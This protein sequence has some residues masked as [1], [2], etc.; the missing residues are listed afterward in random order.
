MKNINL[1]DTRKSENE[2]FINFLNS[3]PLSPPRKLEEQLMKEIRLTWYPQKRT[4]FSKLL[5]IQ[6]TIGTLTMLACPQFQMSLTNNHEVFHYF[7]YHF[8]ET[9]CM[10]ICGSILLG[11]GAVVASL[12]LNKG[13]VRMLRKTKTLSYFSLASIS[14][15]AFLL[16]GA[17]VYLSAAFFWLLGGVVSSAILFESGLIIR[18]EVFS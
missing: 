16:L 6:A 15:F 5:L 3:D 11:S 10:M 14:L 17:E 8:G 2:E 4:V 9:I 13:E 18:E 12:A 1:K 7:H